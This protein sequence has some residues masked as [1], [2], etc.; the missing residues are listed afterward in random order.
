MGWG[1]VKNGA[2]LRAAADAGF[3]AMIT[4]DR[5]MPGQ[6]NPATLPLTVFVLSPT[7]D[8]L[9]SLIAL[10]PALLAALSQTHGKVFVHVA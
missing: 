5:A 2:L 10:A 7:T 9:T 4:T 1:G 3:D 8:Q 6:H